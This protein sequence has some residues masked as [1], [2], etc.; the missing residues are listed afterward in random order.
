MMTQQIIVEIPSQGKVFNK[1]DGPDVY[2]GVVIDQKGANVTP[3]KFIAVLTGNETV[4]GDKVL[5]STSE[6]NVFYILF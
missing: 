2:E 5:K 6:D 3:E 1:P 4:A